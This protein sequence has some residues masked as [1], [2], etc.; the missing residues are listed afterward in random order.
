MCKG[1]CLVFG[2]EI[3]SL[4][5]FWTFARCFRISVV[6]IAFVVKFWDLVIE[7]D[8]VQC[9]FTFQFGVETSGFELAMHVCLL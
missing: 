8:S 2:H 4:M 5:S 6:S 7:K 3:G 9:I 1:W